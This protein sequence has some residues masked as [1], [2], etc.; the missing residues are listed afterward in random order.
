MQTVQ[1]LQGNGKLR[2]KE[3]EILTYLRSNS[4]HT[5]T[6][7]GRKL[8]IPRTTVFE[9]IKKLKKME[10]V[11]KFTCV[12]DFPKLGYSIHAFILF[13]TDPSKK[14]E[15]GE[16]LA[17]SAHT[18]NVA[19]LGNDFDFMAAMI[20]QNMEDMHTYLD[21][22]IQKYQI[23]ETKI[24]YVTKDLKREGFLS[25]SMIKPELD[26]NAEEL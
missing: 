18:N 15:L 13:K 4:R 9:K 5:V 10:I 21:I 11:P 2:K 22:L 1:T 24:M 26:E 19:K 23:K 25:N 12:V 14:E 7:I 20:F 8:G 6:Q 3:L 16:A 17:T